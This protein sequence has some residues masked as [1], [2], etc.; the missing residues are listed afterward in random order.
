MKTRLPYLLPL[1]L[2]LAVL[3]VK[4]PA[5]SAS[6]VV[7]NAYSYSTLKGTN[8]GAVYL[9]LRNEGSQ[10]VVITGVTSDVATSTELHTTTTDERGVTRMNH[11]E[12]I[13]LKPDEEQRFTPGGAHIMLMGVNRPLDVG[14]S[15]ELELL[16]QNNDPL[17]VTITVKPR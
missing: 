17:P 9:T 8:T 3:A 5:A 13:T 14:D 15:F 12:E 4:I 1:L 11:L 10:P 16:Q 7:E 2:I 6:I